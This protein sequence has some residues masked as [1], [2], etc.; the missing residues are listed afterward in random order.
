MSA[1]HEDKL[2]KTIERELAQQETMTNMRRRDVVEPEGRGHKT[3]RYDVRD[4]GQRDI[5]KVV[6]REEGLHSS[7]G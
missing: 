4:G 1:R 6:D 2:A 5:R 7:R 3:P